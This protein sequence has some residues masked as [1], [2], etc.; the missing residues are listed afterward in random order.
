MHALSV[1]N[2]PIAGQSTSPGSAGCVDGFP[3][4]LPSAGACELERWRPSAV[5]CLRGASPAWR[6]E[7]PQAP[8]SNA[9]SPKEMKQ[10]EEFFDPEKEWNELHEGTGS[11]EDPWASVGMDDAEETLPQ[12]QDAGKD[13][14]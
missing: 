6:T 2:Y 4:Q 5:N 7:N 11:E 9:E 14:C 1:E 12:E 13:A 10:A 8:T 3:C